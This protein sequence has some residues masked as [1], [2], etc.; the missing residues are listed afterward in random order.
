M[1]KPIKW[2]C[3]KRR[4]RSASA[5]S[6]KNMGHWITKDSGY[7]V[8]RELRSAFAQS[9]QNMSQW[10]TKDSGYVEASEDSNQYPP[11]LNRI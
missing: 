6:D 10:I 8:A 11:S 9:D 1:T 4:L 3:S 7:V 2:V 5:R